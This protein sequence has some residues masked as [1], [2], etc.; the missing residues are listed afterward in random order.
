MIKTIYR[1]PEIQFVNLDKTPTIEDMGGNQ[2]RVTIDGYT[3]WVD[4]DGVTIVT[5][6]DYDQLEAT[7]LD[8]DTFLAPKHSDDDVFWTAA[9][10]HVANRSEFDVNRYISENI[11][12]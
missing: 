12:W 9:A 10:E 6:E 11:A 3:R 8:D 2:Y 1:E 7:G 4:L 5:N